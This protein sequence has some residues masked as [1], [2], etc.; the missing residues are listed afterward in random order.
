M[1]IADYHCHLSPK[2]IYEDQSFSDLAEA[3][4]AADHYKWRLMR[5]FGISEVYVTG[6]APGKEKFL[7][8]AD[9]LPRAVGNP[10]YQWVHLELKRY[11]GINEPLNSESA[12]RV[13]SAAN[14]RLPEL[15][16]RE[17]IRRSR[18]THIC[19]TDDPADS[20]EYHAKLAK[21]QGFAVYPA[22]RPDKAL[23][24][25]NSGFLAYV[26]KLG[27]ICG[28]AIDSLE[29][30]LSALTLRMDHFGELGCCAA[31]HGVT[32]IPPERAGQ[33]EAAAIFA[34]RLAG[35]AFSMG[36]A[37]RYK[38]FLLKHL[39]A[40]YA[41]RH[42]VMELHMGAVRG[43]N[44][45]AASL[46]ED[47]GFDAIGDTNIEPLARFLDDL[48]SSGSLPKTLLFSLNPC[49]NVA[50]NVLAVCFAPLVQQGAAWWFNDTKA[51]IVDQLTVFAERGVLGTFA[52]M[53]TDSR[54]LFSYS[55][56]E[57]FR[58]LLCA[59][60]GRWV[61]SGEYPSDINMLGEIAR[62]I[63]YRNTIKLFGW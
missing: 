62:D 25:E 3:W 47:S 2:A 51:G 11:F 38:Y 36:E 23:D 58:R 33:A 46:M 54:S 22:F 10:V 35:E 57:Y 60:L 7:K 16:A 26:A 42:W 30:L 9:V 32:R 50:L 6:D 49:D 56:H 27:S 43:V 19:T 8:F 5:I 17:I 40:E 1:P 14:E 15:T 24:I 48:S 53:L 20:L 4:L 61:S 13:W 34:K 12:E 52:G 59:L 21:E 28:A 41:R 29:A 18:V 45:R 37:W 31:D 63:S 44:T 39:A 55:R